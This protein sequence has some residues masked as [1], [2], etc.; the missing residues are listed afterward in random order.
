MLLKGQPG[1]P[2]IKG[3]AG[4]QGPRGA[5]VRSWT[6]VAAETTAESVLTDTCLSVLLQGLDGRDGFGPP[7]PKGVKV[8]F[9]AHE[10]RFNPLSFTGVKNVH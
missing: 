3:A 8:E 9:D 1:P 10:L 6:S 4:S 2:G 5:Q 7:G